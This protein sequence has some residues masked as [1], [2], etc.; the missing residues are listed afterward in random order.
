LPKFGFNSLMARTTA[1]IRLSDLSKVAANDVNLQALK[2][3]G[4]ITKNMKRARVYLSGKIEKKVNLIG[5]KATRG[6]K[7]AIVAAGG[8]VED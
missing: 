8:K 4:V 5:I 3:A 2:D 6:A 7:E 1:Q